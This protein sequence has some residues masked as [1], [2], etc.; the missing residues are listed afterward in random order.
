MAYPDLPPSP[1]F[2]RCAGCSN[3]TLFRVNGIARIEC[4]RCGAI[5]TEAELLAVH[6]RTQPESKPEEPATR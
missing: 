2:W 4:V 6:A 1:T 3:E 5:S